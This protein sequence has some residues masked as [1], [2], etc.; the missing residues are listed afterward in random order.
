M[1]VMV[2]TGAT[3]NAAVVSD[4]EGI[5]MPEGCVAFNSRRSRRAERTLRTFEFSGYRRRP[6]WM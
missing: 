1:V 2:T 4:Y 3:R 5:D 6:D